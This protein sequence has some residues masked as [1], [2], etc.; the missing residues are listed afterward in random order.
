MRNDRV[1][2]PAPARPGRAVHDAGAAGSRARAAAASIECAASARTL[3]AEA[4]GGG[5]I[6]L[7]LALWPVSVGVERVDDCPT[8]DRHAG[9]PCSKVQQAMESVC[10][11]SV[12]QRLLDHSSKALTAAAT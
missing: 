2:D 11:R 5:P 6:A 10:R 8:R 3:E 7:R 1:R 4:D 12:R 9:C